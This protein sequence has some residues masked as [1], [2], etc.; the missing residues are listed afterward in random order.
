MR[1]RYCAWPTVRVAAN[2]IAGRSIPSTGQAVNSSCGMTLQ[3]DG[4][5][6]AATEIDT[7]IVCGGYKI[8]QQTTPEILAALRLIA[9]TKIPIGAL[10]TGAFVLAKAGSVRR[11]SLHNSLGKPL[12]FSRAISSTT[13]HVKS[14]CH[15]WQSLHLCWWRQFYRFNVEV[16]LYSLWP[17][18]GTRNF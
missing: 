12:G 4:A 17:S 11:L 10:C 5:I 7:L 6:S 14:F 8:A 16:S 2:S 1:C 15:R 13:G 9:K 3:F 18:N